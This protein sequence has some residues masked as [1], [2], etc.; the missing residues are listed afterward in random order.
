MIDRFAKLINELKETNS[1]KEKHNILKEYKDD[2]E[3][4]NLFFY[5]Y[6]PYFKYGVTSASLIKNEQMSELHFYDIFEVMDLLRTRKVTGNRAVA[7][8]NGLVSRYLHQSDLMY[9]IFDRNLKIG[10]NAKEINK[11]LDNIIP[12]FDVALAATYDE[13][14]KDKYGLDEYL[15]QRKINGVRLITVITYNNELKCGEVK[16]YSRKGIEYTTCGK[17][18]EE[19]LSYY[20][21]SKYF[22]QN[23]VLDGECCLIDANGKEDWNGIV[24]EIKRKNHTMSNPKYIIFDFLTLEEFSGMKP[25]HDYMWRRDKLLRLFFRLDNNNRFKHLDVILT[26][27]YSKENFDDMMNK[28]VITDMWEG[29]ILRKNC[30]YKSGRSNDLL[31]VK[32]FHDEEFRVKDIEYTTKLMLDPDSGTMKETS[33]V[34]ALVFDI[35]DDTECKVGSGISD[36]QRVE[37]FAHPEKIIGKQI[38]VKYKEKTKSIHTNKTSL[39]FPVL[40]HVFDQDRDF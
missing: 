21:D 4:C 23:V 27:P 18:G 28:F 1:S 10:M 38:L 19:L 6:N 33:C 2:K 7:M 32:L 8:V 9:N 17:I 20:N 3:V 26:V 34:G 12:S 37:W 29:F 15:I 39:E 13:Q 25:S 30:S 24:S 36:S 14:K 31:K 22:G 16:F 5:T 11:A 35:D 40:L